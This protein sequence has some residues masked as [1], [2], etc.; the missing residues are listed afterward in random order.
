MNMFHNLPP[1]LSA[2][3][4]LS[5]N[6][7]L[8]AKCAFFHNVSNASLVALIAEFRAFVYIPEQN[9]AKQGMPLTACFFINR[10]SCRSSRTMQC[11]AL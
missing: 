4:D 1:A 5:T 3:L 7:R 8:A 9:V 10:A 6:R 11:R 2:Q